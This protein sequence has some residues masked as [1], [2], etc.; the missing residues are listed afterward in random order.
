MRVFDY[1]YDFTPEVKITFPRWPCFLG[2]MPSLAERGKRGNQHAFSGFL[3]NLFEG[4]TQFLQ[5]GTDSEKS[6][7]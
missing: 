3:E 5:G 2:L 1:L 7:L 6:R 4:R